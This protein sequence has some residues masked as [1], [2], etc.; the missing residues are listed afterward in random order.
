MVFK[1]HILDHLSLHDNSRSFVVLTA[2]T[3]IKAVIRVQKLQ[4]LE[5]LMFTATCMKIFGCVIIILPQHKRIHWIYTIRLRIIEPLT[6]SS[7][8]DILWKA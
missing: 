1:F 5:S 8:Q 4:L 6:Y 7:V 3:F 2:A